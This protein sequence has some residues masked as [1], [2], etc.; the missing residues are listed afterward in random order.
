MVGTLRFSTLHQESFSFRNVKAFAFLKRFSPAKSKVSISLIQNGVKYQNPRLM[1]FTHF[2][3]I[4]C[5][6]DFADEKLSAI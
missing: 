3:P 4:Q 6:C 1:Y 5:S 2:T